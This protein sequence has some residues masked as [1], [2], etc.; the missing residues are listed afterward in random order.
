MSDLTFRTKDITSLFPSASYREFRSEILRKSIHFLIGLSPLLA[1]LSYPV[2][3]ILLSAGI[4]GYV[5]MESLRLAGFKVPVVSNLTSMASRSRDRG[6]FVLGPVTL[7][8]GALLA[9]VLYPTPAASI[10]IYALA[11]GDGFASLVGR[12]FGRIRPSFLR[13]KSLEGSLACFTAVLAAA[14]QVSRDFRLALI[15]AFAAT[16]TEALP[17][18]DY[19]NLALPLVVGLVV[20]IASG[21]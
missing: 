1:A 19:D 18:E 7:G 8:L 15:A 17:L 13:G 10:A 21:L 12:F 14:Y 9:L 6:R 16:V 11:F 20:S 3:V 5:Q 2:T 4:L